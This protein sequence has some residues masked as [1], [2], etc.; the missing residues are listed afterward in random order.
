MGKKRSIKFLNNYFLNKEKEYEQLCN[1]CG[2]CC[3]AYDGDPCVHLKKDNK[4]RYYCA[5]YP[6][7]LGDQKTVSGE[8]FECVPISEIINNSWPG[9]HLCAYKR[10]AAQAY[11]R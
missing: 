2:A 4:G 5:V 1:R 11:K 3:G 10:L 9:G 7:R 6:N 8:D